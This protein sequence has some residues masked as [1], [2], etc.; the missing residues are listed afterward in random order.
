MLVLVPKPIT[1]ELCKVGVCIAPEPIVRDHT[2]VPSV[3]T[4]AGKLAEV[5]HTGAITPAFTVKLLFVIVILVEAVHVLFVTVHFKGLAPEAKLL[6]I[7]SGSVELAKFILESVLVQAPV[8]PIKVG[9]LALRFAV[10][11]QTLSSEETA[12]TG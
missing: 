1:K 9:S 10:F 8:A 5:E 4:S 3:N 11:A 2:P 6:T 7:V 12:T